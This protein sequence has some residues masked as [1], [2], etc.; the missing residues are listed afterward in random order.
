[1]DL[2]FEGLPE[3]ECG[4]N[5][6]DIVF[7]LQ[8]NFNGKIYVQGFAN[9]SKCVAQERG[10]RT[11]SISIPKDGCGVTSLRSVSAAPILDS[12]IRSP[13]GCH[14][15]LFHELPFLGQ[16]A[17]TRRQRESADFLSSALCNES[18]PRVRAQL[19][20]HGSGQDGYVSIDR[21]YG[22]VGTHNRACRDAEMRLP[23]TNRIQVPLT[24]RSS[25]NGYL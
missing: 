18:G 24:T 13:A 3:I 16:P 8:D 4:Q 1:M 21:E 19:L 25:S 6:I 15:L 17:W 23:G 22:R 11:T 5:S 20:L 12:A 2:C 7:N 10:R 9:D 14:G